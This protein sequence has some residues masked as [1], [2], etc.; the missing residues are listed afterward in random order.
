MGR[1]HVARVIAFLERDMAMSN[2][3]GILGVAAASAAAVI[4]WQQMK[5]ML[6]ASLMQYLESKSVRDARDLV[7]QNADLIKGKSDI[8]S[9][10]WDDELRQAAA[11]ICASYNVAG[12]L[13]KKG[14]VSR[15]IVMGQ[16]GISARKLRDALADFIKTREDTEGEKLPFGFQMARGPF[17]FLPQ[18]RE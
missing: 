2:F 5:A 11:E 14:M 15:S 7:R 4:Y 17:T 1:E 18:E 3:V 8:Y 9:P 16:W 13:T 10:P 6:L 12:H